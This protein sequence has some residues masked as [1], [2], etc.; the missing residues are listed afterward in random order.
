M[1]ITPRNICD[2]HG[3]HHCLEIA[4]DS[5]LLDGRPCSFLEIT[6]E[7]IDIA[8]QDS[9]QPITLATATFWRDIAGAAPSDADAGELLAHRL[10]VWASQQALL[11]TLQS[12][13]VQLRGQGTGSP[14]L[15]DRRLDPL[16][17]KLL[18]KFDGTDTMAQMLADILDQSPDV[19][20]RWAEGL[21]QRAGEDDG[22]AMEQ[23]ELSTESE[24]S[25][26]TGPLEALPPTEPVVA[27]TAQQ[28]SR[29]AQGEWFFWDP[30]REKVLE[31]AV[32]RA[33][34]LDQMTQATM[35][36]IAAKLG[37]PPNS[38]EYKIYR[39]KK[40]SRLREQPEQA[41]PQEDDRRETASGERSLLYAS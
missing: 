3:N 17:E 29:K 14:L 24:A 34:G 31:E 18:R 23:E 9:S 20:R 4:A 12:L 39:W 41:A 7:R 10:A 15:P 38:V 11:H 27:T 28:R 25:I 32:T 30:E 6:H 21:A 22:A 2:L 1:T 37:W 13:Q 8:H 33:G 16:I 5:L 26:S 19:V 35:K 36:Q 40:G